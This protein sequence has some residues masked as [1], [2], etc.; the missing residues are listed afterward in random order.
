M[1]ELQETC[2]PTTTWFLYS[3]DDD[4]LGTIYRSSLPEVGAHVEA[5]PGFNDA[6]IMN[7]AELQATCSMRR[8]R[9][10]VR[11]IA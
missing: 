1:S 2:L 9:V 4:P 6:L 11:V 10:D 3:E 7:V 8:F 5:G